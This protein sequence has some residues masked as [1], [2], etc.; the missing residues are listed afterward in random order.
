MS[1]KLKSV[2]DELEGAG[3]ITTDDDLVIE[4]LNSD[5]GLN[6]HHDLVITSQEKSTLRNA[7]TALQVLAISN[8][9]DFLQELSEKALEVLGA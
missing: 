8:A 5:L 7:L 4:T 3:M 6:I 2:L 9:D 1:Y